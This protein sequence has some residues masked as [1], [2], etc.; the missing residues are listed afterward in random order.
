M[1]INKELSLKDIVKKC[2]IDIERQLIMNVLK[3]TGGNKSKAARQLKID[4]TTMHLK[5]KEYCIKIDD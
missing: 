3:R 5:V 4:Y 1:D 2:V